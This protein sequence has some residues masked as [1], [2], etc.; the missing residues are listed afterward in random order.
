MSPS[1]ELFN[2]AKYK[3]LMDG[4]E[5]VEIPFKELATI[6]DY[7]IESE[8]FSKK[9]IEN[10]KI[11]INMPH[12]RFNQIATASNGRA[13]SSESFSTDG[14]IYISKIGDVTNK[15]EIDVWEKVSLEEFCLQKGA[16]LKDADILITLTGDPP[17]VGKVNMVSPNRR[18]C[19]W[20]Q[21]VARIERLGNDYISNYALYAVLSSEVCRIQME[22]FAKGIR[23]RNLGNDCFTFVEIPILCLKLQ[24]ALDK[25]IQNHINL[26]N[27]AQEQYLKVE[28][29]LLSS[30]GMSDFTSFQKNK[31]ISVKLFSESCG[32][33][34][35]M[36][37]EY[38]QMKYEMYEN[39]VFTISKGYTYVKEQFKL[40]KTKCLRD[41]NAYNYVEIGDIDVG[42]GTA[43]S[44]T[45]ETNSLPDNAKIMTK[46]G[47][48]LVSTVRPNRGAV[49]ILENDNILVSGA[50][51][52]LREKG[53]YPKELLQALFR[54]SMY[55]DWL[56]RFNVGTS[57]PVIRDMDV[58][59][60]PIPVFEKNIENTIVSYVK[61]ASFLRCQSKE[62]IEYAKQAVEIS[63]E[64]DE[65]KAIEWLKE[66]GV[67]C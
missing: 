5:I 47:D 37:A 30:L 56:L 16:L 55:K 67:E 21:R 42:D 27:R 53:N 22:R 23:Q 34:G 1:V 15:R 60:M 63:I 25:L 64:Q 31:D 38:Y 59:N 61:K 40:I 24:Q 48:I 62:L 9:F 45:I 28:Q 7:R 18:R 3:A 35:R 8:Y 50:F 49:A 66:K 32:L 39:A 44:K 12:K 46:I 54:T 43:Y 41:L 51:T 29:L 58:L 33:S 65:E 14:E 20:N 13:Y 36:D 26:L 57:Y 6:I 19:T 17:D 52:V 2:E 4:L 10:E 11:L